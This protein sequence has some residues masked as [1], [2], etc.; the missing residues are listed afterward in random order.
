MRQPQRLMGRA[1]DDEQRALGLGP[2]ELCAHR[3]LG[4]QDVTPERD[5]ATACIEAAITQDPRDREAMLRSEAGRDGR[6][7]GCGGQGVY[8]IGLSSM[9]AMSAP[10]TRPEAWL[11]Y[12]WKRSWLSTPTS[13]GS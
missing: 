3:G 12:L 11:Q 10:T 9:S 4:V 13:I 6:R 8:A 1:E 2:Q 7:H 5:L